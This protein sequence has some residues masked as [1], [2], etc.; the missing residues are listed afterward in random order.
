MLLIPRVK[1]KS[2]AEIQH[3]LAI[4]LFDCATNETVDCLPALI[5]LIESFYSKRTV[6]RKHTISQLKLLTTTINEDEN[7]CEFI[8]KEFFEALRLYFDHKMI[9]QGD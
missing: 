3:K 7:N 2:E 6:E 4:L 1:I 9:G 5:S 8:R